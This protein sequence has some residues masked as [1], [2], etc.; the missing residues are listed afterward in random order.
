MATQS[1]SS[2]SS[3]PPPVSVGFTAQEAVTHIQDLETQ[4]A[5]ANK[6]GNRLLAAYNAEKAALA[7][8]KAKSFAGAISRVKTP[9]VPSFRGEIGFGVDSWLR[10]LLKQF[11]FYGGTTF[12]DEESRIRYAVMFLDGPAMDWWDGLSDTEKARLVTWKLFVEALYSRFRPMQASTVARMR[13]SALKQTGSVSAFINVFQR[14]LTPISDMSEADRMHYFR[15]GLK[16]QIAQRVLEKLPKTLHE[17]MDMAILADAHFSK[18]TAPL[19]YNSYNRSN[20]GGNGSSSQRA[21]T[22]GSSD[23]DLSNVNG[24]DS[25]DES[26]RPPVFHEEETA[27]SSAPGSQVNMMRELNRM[28]AEVKKYQA[29]AAISAFGSSSSSS[30]SSSART[31]VSK[32]VF[33]YCWKNRLCLK[34]KKPGHVASE[35]RSKVQPLNL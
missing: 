23:M 21:A 29:Q 13:L 3:S 11:D 4:L 16:P 10:R 30:S 34:C 15:A 14:E 26:L 27:P 24:D 7:V 9:V 20:T 5:Q 25:T 17:A 35:C 32:E 2:S 19:F 33:D 6:D 31:P 12:P 8:E 28:K 18:T 22:A 1:S